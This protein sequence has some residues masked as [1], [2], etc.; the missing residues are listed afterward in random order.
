MSATDVKDRRFSFF[1]LKQQRKNS[2]PLRRYVSDMNAATA[3]IKGGQKMTN[4]LLSLP[5]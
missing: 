3:V 1:L 5:A 2:H 4:A